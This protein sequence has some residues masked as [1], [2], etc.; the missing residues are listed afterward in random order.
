VESCKATFF[1]ED[2]ARKA[3]VLAVF[4]F[5]TGHTLRLFHP[6][7][8]FITEELWHGLGFSAEMPSD[9]GGQTIMTAHWPKAFEDDFK[10]HYA[11]DETIDELVAAKHELVTAGRNL[12]GIGNIPFAKKIDYIIKPA[13]KLG[14]YEVKVIQSLL[15]AES[16]KVDADYAPRKGTPAARSAL[17]ELYLPLD[18]LVDVEA[19]KARLEKQMEKFAAEIAKASAKLNNPKFTE[20]APEEVLQEARERLAEWQQKEQQTREAIEYLAEA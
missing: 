12:R 5:V 9:Q 15:N 19:E 6:F 18:G 10:E 16:L 11:L 14:A 7:M 1:G 17:G 8:P 3:N 4:D 13:A 2:A 20:R